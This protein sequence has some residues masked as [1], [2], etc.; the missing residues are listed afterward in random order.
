MGAGVQ[1]WWLDGRARA[2]DEIGLGTRYLDECD[3][4]LY[5]QS[6]M[7]AYYI[8]RASAR[9]LLNV[10]TLIKAAINCENECR[11]SH[12]HRVLDVLTRQ[13]LAQLG[14]TA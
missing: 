4:W 11:K 12:R 10:H 2:R 13:R 14:V 7:L 5:L 1:R 3:E 8:Q 9:E 6:R